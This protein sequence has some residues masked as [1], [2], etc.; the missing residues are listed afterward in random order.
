[1]WRLNGYPSCGLNVPC[2]RKAIVGTLAK[3]VLMSECLA[4]CGLSVGLSL[5]TSVECWIYDSWVDSGSSAPRRIDKQSVVCHR[6]MPPP[7]LLPPLNGLFAHEE[8]LTSFAKSRYKALYSSTSLRYILN[9]AAQ[10]CRIC[11]A[12]S[13]FSPLSAPYLV[14]RHRH[15]LIVCF[16]IF[17]GTLMA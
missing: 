7:P 1:M 15:L 10:S 9:T 8:R 13:F 12:S 14:P 16:S 2:A 3:P 5:Y 4:A 17:A 6:V 11:K